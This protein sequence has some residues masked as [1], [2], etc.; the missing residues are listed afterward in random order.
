MYD[1]EEAK[2]TPGLPPRWT[3][4]RFLEELVYDFI[5]PGRS[6]NN[7]VID[8]ESMGNSDSSARTEAS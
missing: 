4:V 6:K 7:V 8:P 2:K 1:E 5:F 3:H